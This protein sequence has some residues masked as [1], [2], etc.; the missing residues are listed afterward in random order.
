MKTGLRFITRGDLYQR[1]DGGIVL[2]GRTTTLLLIN[3]R[4]EVV[5]FHEED[6][7]QN[8]F[9]EEFQDRETLFEE[10]WNFFE[11]KLDN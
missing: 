6:K 11:K 2:L 5:Y 10:E 7:D 4:R 3:N 9:I 8:L 1:K